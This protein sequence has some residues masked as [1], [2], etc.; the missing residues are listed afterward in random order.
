MAIARKAARGTALLWMLAQRSPALLARRRF[1]R[2]AER[3]LDPFRRNAPPSAADYEDLVRYFAVGWRSYRTA[4]GT[5]AAY[6]GLPSWSG[7]RVDAIE[8]FSRLMPLFGAWCASGRETALR[9][10]GGG[11]LDLAHEFRRG[12]LT[13][14]DPGSPGYWG[15]M[16]GTSNQRI[17]EAADIALALWLFR[18]S[19]W[20]QLSA[21]ER[22]AV[23]DWLSLIEGRPGLD[24]NWHLFFVLI[25]RVLAALGHPGR[26]TSAAQRWDRIKQFH[27][28]DGWFTDGPDGRVDFYSAWG[29][30]YALGWIDC[31]D[32]TWDSAFI[33]DCQRRF[34]RTY[35]HLI[36]PDG[37]PML[38]RSV[39]YRI[40]APAPLLQGCES[41]P[42]VVSAGEARRALDCV[43]R[44]FIRHGALRHGVATQGYHGDDPRL[45]DPYSGPASGLWSLRSLIAAMH[46]PRGSALW[47]STGEP[48]PV[49][50]GDFELTAAGSRWRV[51]G[52]RTTGVVTIEVLDNPPDAAP[53]LEPVSRLQVLRRFAAE[54]FAV[55][56]NMEAKYGRRIYR[57]DRP[58]GA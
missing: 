9:L 28:G 25:D 1:P 8:G 19:V 20:T 45:L 12:L 27:L 22:Q 10:P 3:L 49:E 43:W 24:N 46:Q 16:P 35:R 50:R 53:E 34:L 44:H 36:A 17:V 58:F 5:G 15:D 54:S 31:I 47:R 30:H 6:P 32:P 7:A 48:L 18:D 33:R 14:T 23:V 2:E 26:I 40:A 39:C 57:S 42:D 11:A 55:P 21:A 38:G 56:R 52:E 13:G 51:R 29:F 37:L 41:H 4:D